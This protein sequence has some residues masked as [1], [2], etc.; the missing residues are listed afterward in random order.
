MDALWELWESLVQLVVALWH[1]LLTL[2]AVLLPWLPLLAW[3]VF[4]LFAVNWVSLRQVLLRGGWIGL[5]LIGLVMILVWGVVA[6]PVGGAHHLFGL[7][8][9]NFVGKTV[10]VTILFC[11]MFLCGAFQLSGFYTPPE[12]PVEAEAHAVAHHDAG[13]HPAPAHHH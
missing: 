7:T 12:A 10:F 6:P 4:W 11:I 3:I 13:H 9:S 5:L 1:L 8:L 2:G